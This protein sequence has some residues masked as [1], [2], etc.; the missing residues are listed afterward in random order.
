[1]SSQKCFQSIIF[2]QQDSRHVAIHVYLHIPLSLTTIGLPSGNAYYLQSIT[3]KGTHFLYQMSI[4]QDCIDMCIWL[5]GDGGQ[6]CC[7]AVGGC[8]GYWLLEGEKLCD[9]IKHVHSLA[10]RHQSAGTPSSLVSFCKTTAT[11]GRW[12]RLP[13]QQSSHTHIPYI[14]RSE[15]KGVCLPLKR[16]V[17]YLSRDHP[18]L[19]GGRK[20]MRQ[21][22]LG[23]HC[24][25]AYLFLRHA[26]NCAPGGRGRDRVDVDVFNMHA[27]QPPFRAL[28]AED[29]HF[30]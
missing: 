7:G 8:D 19:T 27:K 22:W 9:H 4:Y 23:N 29:N 26:W 2:N 5:A 10:R 15:Q 6:W 1:M 12:A 17:V 20:F 21:K 13:T 28:F 25:S 18:S 24:L 3:S 30:D 16:R 11:S 14:L